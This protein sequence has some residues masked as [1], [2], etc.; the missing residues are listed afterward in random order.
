MKILIYIFV[1]IYIISIQISLIRTVVNIIEPCPVIISKGSNWPS[2]SDTC[3]SRYRWC[4]SDV[5]VYSL[6]LGRCTIILSTLTRNQIEIW[7]CPVQ[8]LNAP[9]VHS[10]CWTSHIHLFL[11]ASTVQCGSM[12]LFYASSCMAYRNR[13]KYI[14]Y[15]DFILPDGK[16]VSSPMDNYEEW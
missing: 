14:F 12:D 6:F 8:P 11:S 4:R 10:P 7:G 13:P 5:T 9:H 15:V 1:Y 16:C 3:Y 2:P